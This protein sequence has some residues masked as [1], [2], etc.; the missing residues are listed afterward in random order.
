MK[1]P[2]IILLVLAMSSCAPV[3]KKDLMEAGSREPVLNDI[4]KAPDRHIGKLYILGGVIVETKIS[5]DMSS[6][7]AIYIPVDRYGGLL[8]P[9]PSTSR[10]RAIISN[11]KG[12]LDPMIYRSGRKVTIAGEVKGTEKG[13]IGEMNYTF[14]LF[15]IRD[16]Y[17]WEERVVYE[18]EYPFFYDMYYPF[19]YDL[20]Y[21][22][23]IGPYPKRI[24]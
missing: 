20:H 7:E 2:L 4:A 18:V 11:S 17:L 19:Y 12:I 6:I 21:Y 1:R 8:E 22:D 23:L 13:M 10:F 15:E 9:A 5:D 3:I 14:P 24:K 16:I